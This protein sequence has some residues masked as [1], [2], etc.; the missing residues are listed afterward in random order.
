MYEEKRNNFL[1]LL[2][3]CSVHLYSPPCPHAHDTNAAARYTKK[4]AG[5]PQNT[6]PG[7]PPCSSPCL[8]LVTN[9]EEEYLEVAVAEHVYPLRYLGR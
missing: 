5:P 8:P 7:Q 3:P 6:Q 4:M 9:T 1:S 2:W